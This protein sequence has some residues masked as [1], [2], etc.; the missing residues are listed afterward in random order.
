M[1]RIRW[2]DAAKGWGIIFV[3]I[4]HLGV[5]RM[6]EIISLFVMPL[7]F[8]LSGYVTKIETFTFYQLISNAIKKSDSLFF[9]SQYYDPDYMGK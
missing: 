6:G 7:F 8:F 3:I 1:H 5:G 4:L 9:V 2:V